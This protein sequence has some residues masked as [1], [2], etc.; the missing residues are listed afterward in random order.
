MCTLLTEVCREHQVTVLHVTHSRAEADRLAD[1]R[2]R[3]AD[4][5]ISETP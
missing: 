4:G 3:F 5:R 1:L 2:L